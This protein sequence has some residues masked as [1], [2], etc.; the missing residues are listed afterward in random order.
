MTGTVVESKWWLSTS[1]HKTDEELDKD[2]EWIEKFAATTDVY[3]ICIARELE[4]GADLPHIHMAV[5]LTRSM[6]PFWGG[7]SDK[8]RGWNNECPLTG[9]ED[10]WERMLAYVKKTGS[11]YH[12]REVIPYPYN[13][14]KP[15]WKPWQQWVLDQPRE[16][17]K[18]IVIIDTVGGI[19]KTFLAG[20]HDCRYQ[21]IMVPPFDSHRD[22]MRYV[23]SHKVI[24]DVY[25]DI[26]RALSKDKMRTIYAGAE[27]IKDGKVYDERYMLQVRRFSTP[28]VVIF[29]ND[30]PSLSQLSLDRWIFCY[31]FK[32]GSFKV[33]NP[34]AEG[35]SYINKKKHNK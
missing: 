9:G 7:S 26:P 29:T 16:N 35:H 11:Y 8:L 18:I 5:R 30:E 4:E 2:M 32:D 25:I 20:W 13:V 24:H 6:T 27:S 33:V 34:L 10:G 22:I 15:V 31:P 12:R 1:P 23:M 3:D 19:G 17:R 28:K 21:A 14:D